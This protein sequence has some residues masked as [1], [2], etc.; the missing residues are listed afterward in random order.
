MNNP[1]KVMVVSFLEVKVGSAS[2]EVHSGFDKQLLY[3]VR[4]RTAM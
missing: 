1:Q 3:V 2:V 4:R